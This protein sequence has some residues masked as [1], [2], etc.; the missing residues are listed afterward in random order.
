[1]AELAGFPYFE[2]Q[3]TK[4]G[5]PFD[6]RETEAVLDAVRGGA[7]GELF[8]ISHGWNNDIGE[9]R[10]L[11]RAF[12]REVRRALDAGRAPALA[13]RRIAALGVLWPSKRFADEDLIPGGGASLGGGRWGAASATG[14]CNGSWTT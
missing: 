4:Q 8:A 5:E 12:F 11:Y 7:I 6:R 2:V 10:N 14:P 9:A 1:M 3:F 13:G